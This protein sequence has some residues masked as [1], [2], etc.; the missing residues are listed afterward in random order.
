MSNDIQYTLRVAAESGPAAQ[1]FAVD[2]NAAFDKINAG[3]DKVVQQMAAQ[4][5]AMQKMTTQGQQASQA[6]TQQAQT[7]DN[8]ADRY[9]K[10]VAKMDP[11]AKLQQQFNQGTKTLDEALN[12]GH[13]TLDGYNADMAKLTQWHKD[14]SEAAGKHST[15]AAALGMNFGTMT[16]ELRALG[17]EATAGR[18]KNFDSTLIN[19]MGHA[20]AANPEFIALGA[21]I[22]AAGAV[23]IGFAAAVAAGYNEQQKFNE[24]L[25]MTGNYSGQTLGTIKE[26]TQ[27]YKDAGGNAGTFKEALLELAASGKITGDNIN[28]IAKVASDLEEQTGTPVKNTI[29]QFEELGKSPVE[30]SI[31]LNDQY[32]YLTQAVFDQ[33]EALM[34]QGDAIDAAKVAQDAFADATATRT[35]Q[36]EADVGI[37]VGIWRSLKNEISGAIDAV[38]DFGKKTS[39]QQQIKSVSDQIDSNN[40]L[41]GAGL[42]GDPVSMVRNWMN[43]G[44]SGIDAQN[45][46]LYK[47]RAD[48][49]KQLMTQNEAAFEESQN[50][51]REQQSITDELFIRGIETKTNRQYKMTQAVNE[52]IA[53][54]ERERA[55]NPNDEKYSQSAQDEAVAAI[56]ARYG[57]HQRK[58]ASGVGAVNA[59]IRNQAADYQNDIKQ[60]DDDFRNSTQEVTAL[61]HD[62]LISAQQYYDTIIPKIYEHNNAVR[63]DIEAEIALLEAQKS[64]TN[65]TGQ[66]NIDTQ[67][68]GLREKEGQLAQDTAHQ[69]AQAATVYESAMK[70]QQDAVTN[71]AEALDQKATTAQEKWNT[72][73]MALSQGSYTTQ[74]MNAYDALAKQFDTEKEKL[75]KER[76]KAGPDGESTYQSNLAKLQAYYDN[77][78]AMTK[79][80]YDRMDAVRG[81]WEAGVKRGFENFQYEAQDAASQS[82]TA[83]K[84]FSSG[85]TNA[86]V[87]FATT[88]RSSFSSFA[89][90]VIQ[91]IIK[92]EVQAT[93]SKIFGLIGNLIGAYFGGVST[94]GSENAGAAYSSTPDDLI[95]SYGKAAV[96]HSGDI[97]GMNSM[98]R[99]LNMSAFAGASRYHTGGIVDGE[100]PI[101]AQKGEAVMPTV[102]MSDG[103]L[104]VKMTNSQANGNNISIQTPVTLN[105]S[106]QGGGSG[107]SQSDM[108]DF[109][110]QMGDHLQSVMDQRIAKWAQDQTRPGG[111]LSGNQSSR[112]GS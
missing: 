50:K 69:V 54:F 42:E 11:A 76:A 41:K 26:M 4:S 59:D 1:Q 13:I 29:K 66:K 40:H 10:L 87:Q 96:S 91:D 106:Y 74:Q 63:A 57:P 53:A 3:L 81:D 107:N 71:Y 62:R 88:G 103:T 14:A 16:R 58:G 92:M 56:K 67:I 80:G 72:Q 84:D 19:I 77:M 17:D 112:M 47:Q 6:N 49:E 102:R 95:S 73:V 52:T 32:H 15:M 43:G 28:Y 38:M 27:A 97:A 37:L 75:D 9:D 90:S 8:L 110:N 98:Y 104:G 101:I 48:L 51:Q 24:A 30:A 23:F 99:S 68:K 65:A 31:K 78:V 61:F 105:V 22:L 89:L 7:L 94:A 109:A 85:L 55:K 2:L 44:D 93:E 39:L 33:I 25:I 108:N 45:A 111:A 60:Q 35:K 86:I 20:A 18:W 83:F 36:M 5:A 64:R 82:E 70:K 12:K 79:D 46:T 34:K 21:T 100:V